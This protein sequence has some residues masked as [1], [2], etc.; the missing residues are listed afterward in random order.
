MT[1]KITDTAIPEIPHLFCEVCLMS[2]KAS[3]PGWKEQGPDLGQHHVCG[4]CRRADLVS[5]V[6]QLWSN[7]MPHGD[8]TAALK[9]IE[10]IMR[11]GADLDA[12]D[13]EIT[14]EDGGA[15]VRLWQPTHRLIWTSNGR[16]RTIYVAL[17]SGGLDLGVHAGTGGPAYTEQDWMNDDEASWERDDEGTWTFRG[18]ALPPTDELV[19]QPLTSEADARPRATVMVAPTFP[20]MM[21]DKEI[22]V[23]QGFSNDPAPT[24]PTP[25]T[26][27]ARHDATV[28]T[29][30]TEMRAYVHSW[31]VSMNAHYPGEQSY[32]DAISVVEDNLDVAIE[33]A[34]EHGVTITERDAEDWLAAERNLNED[35][36][37]A[38]VA[39]VPQAMRDEASTWVSALADAF[40][41][42]DGSATERAKKVRAGAYAETLGSFLSC[43][44]EDY[45]H[46]KDAADFG[47]RVAATLTGL[48]GS[49]QS[50]IGSARKQGAT[51]W[52][53]ARAIGGE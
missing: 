36:P 51:P 50:D 20:P 46:A 5:R 14:E 3:L 39:S 7:S 35:R 22:M 41:N 44:T 29:L 27:D 40:V 52:D 13:A 48:F 12:L 25:D 43:L 11:A 45:E 17:V 37:A 53:F 30:D 38:E 31:H 32:C 21:T 8:E 49:L 18:N 1:T 26:D 19:V 16:V 47:A 33:L 28:H 9:R 34:A 6:L 4:A 15:R 24:T 2:G 10:E 42:D 23:A